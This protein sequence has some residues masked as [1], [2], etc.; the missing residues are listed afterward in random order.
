MA[1]TS[2][3]KRGLVLQGFFGVE[4]FRGARTAVAA[5]AVQPSRADFW[6]GKAPRPDLMPASPGSR[7]PGMARPTLPAQPAQRGAAQLRSVVRP[8]VVTAPVPDGRLRIAGDG[9]PLD[10]GIRAHIERVLGADLSAV[11][12]HEGPAAPAM[13]ALAFTLGETV[14]FAPGLYNPT[15]PAGVE[16]LG[17]EL[18]HVVQQRQGRVA[19]PYGRGIAIVQDPALEAEA[20]ATG[21]RVAQAMFMVAGAALGGGLYGWT[22]AAIGGGLGYLVDRYRA[23]VRR[24][25]VVEQTQWSNNLRLIVRGLGEAWLRAGGNPNKAKEDNEC[26]GPGWNIKDEGADV[27]LDLSDPERPGNVKPIDAAF[28]EDSSEDHS[29]DDEDEKGKRKVKKRDDTPRYQKIFTARYADEDDTI[30][31]MILERRKEDDRQPNLQHLY[32]RWLVGHPT[33]QGGGSKLVEKAK[34]IARDH[35]NSELRVDSAKSAVSWYQKQGFAKLYEAKHEDGVHPCRCQF[36]TW[37]PMYDWM[38]RWLLDRVNA[39]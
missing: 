11:R 24:E 12:V 31:V 3:S 4:R 19:N 33:K 28:P 21:Q 5:R 34:Q 2:G 8:G 7:L 30:A 25:V 32:I 27:A 23:P 18:T 15:T 22:G 1:L 38:P 9:K 29:G 16:L 36:M 17:H 35:F 26:S 20:D 6:A 39:G 37:R 10:R 13:G 14:Y